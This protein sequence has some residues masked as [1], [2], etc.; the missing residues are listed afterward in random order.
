VRVKIPPFLLWRFTSRANLGTL[1]LTVFLMSVAF[2]NLV[3]ITSLFNGILKGTDAQFVNAYVGHVTVGPPDGQPVLQHAGALLEKISDAPGVAG[4]SAQLSFLGSLKLGTKTIVRQVVAVDPA[5][6]K[7]VTDVGDKI[8][9]GAYLRPEDED[10]ILLGA[11]IAGGPGIEPNPDSFKQAHVGDQVA[12]T[13]NGASRTFTVRGVFQTK[14]IISDE[15]AL[16]SRRAL[17]RLN[18]LLA[19]A[20]TGF[21]IRAQKDGQEQAIIAALRE[22]GVEGTFGTWQDSAGIMKSVTKSFRSIDVLMSFVGLLIAAVTIF[23]VVY[24]DVL[25]H[26]RQIGIL[27]A[28]GLDTWMIRATY[29]LQSGLYALAGVA[30]GSGVFFGALVPYFRAHPFSLP[31][32]D[33]VL[34]TNPRDYLARAG[35]VVLVAFVSGLIPAVAV[36]RMNLLDAVIGK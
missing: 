8:I 19:D 35:T 15:R 4:A 27:R 23:I 3:F 32:C 31:L 36:T 29:V 11:Q 7:T 13:L 1:A 16:I 21:I 24:I 33:A 10:G 20:A 12:V 9:A 14:L 5:R 2:I 17:E 34:L 25:N 18:P 28:I 22:R 30:V 6:E 26:K